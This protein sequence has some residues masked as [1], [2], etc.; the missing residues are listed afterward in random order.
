[1]F[2]KVKVTTYEL[3]FFRTVRTL[4]GHTSLQNGYMFIHKL[5]GSHNNNNNNIF[6]T[7][8]LKFETKKFKIYY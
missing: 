8:N 7:N 6:M 3:F 1:M 4:L 5:T 2:L